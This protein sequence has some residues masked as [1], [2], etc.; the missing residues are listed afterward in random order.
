MQGQPSLAWML[1]K[2]LCIVPIPGS[3]ELDCTRKNSGEHRRE[4][5][6]GSASSGEVVQMCGEKE[7]VVVSWTLAPSARLSSGGPTRGS[8]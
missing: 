4:R 8:T 6:H 1:C 3:R 5:G 2:E 7:D